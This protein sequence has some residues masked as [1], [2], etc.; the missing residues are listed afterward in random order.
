ME[1]VLSVSIHRVS[2]FSRSTTPSV[3]SERPA[4]ERRT[5]TVTRD[6]ARPPRDRRSRKR[7]APTV[8]QLRTRISI[9]QKHC[10]VWAITWRKYRP[11]YGPEFWIG[12]VVPSRQ[13]SSSSI[14]V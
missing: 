6:F 1:R 9:S 14:H 13:D 5:W 2:C 12:D 3:S 8:N 10:Y 4:S 7:S 11:S